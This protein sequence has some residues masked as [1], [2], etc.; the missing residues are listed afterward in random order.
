M[1]DYD[2]WYQKY[3]KRTHADM[4]AHIKYAMRTLPGEYL[5]RCSREGYAVQLMPISIP[6]KSR[7]ACRTFSVPLILVST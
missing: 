6:A 3:L 1:L 2:E 7:A 4:G 5:L